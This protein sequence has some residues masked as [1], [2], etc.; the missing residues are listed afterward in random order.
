MSSANY[1]AIDDDV[2]AAEPR[3]QQPQHD[4][5]PAAPAAAVAAASGTPYLAKLVIAYTSSNLLALS[6][7][8][9]SIMS[10]LLFLLY[11]KSNLLVGIIACVYGLSS[12]GAAMGSA[13]ISD[14]AG[15]VYRPTVLY[16][17]AGLG[18]VGVAAMSAAVA[19]DYSS[20]GGLNRTADE[21][22]SLPLYVVGNFLCG[23]Y[24][25]ASSANV[26]T[27]I[28]SA[29]STGQRDR[30]YA[31]KFVFETLAGVGGI[32]SS[33]VLFLVVGND[34][35]LEALSYGMFLGLFV[36]ALT[37]ILLCMVARADR[38]HMMIEAAA[39]AAAPSRS[40]SVISS[41]IATAAAAPAPAAVATTTPKNERGETA[42]DDRDAND[43]DDDRAAA[44]CACW[45]RAPF[46]LRR[47]AIPYVV[48][49]QAVIVALGS[50]MTMRFLVLF[51]L[52]DYGASPIAVV[53]CLFSAIVLQAI[54]AKLNQLLSTPREA[55]DGSG[56]RRPLTRI[57]TTWISRV[58]GPLGLVWIGVVTTGA[59]A[60]MVPTMVV[61]AL[62]LAIMNSTV[63]LTR[64][65]TIDCVPVDSRA[66]WN[67]VESVLGASWAGSALL[68]GY[69][70]DLYGYRST[71]L[72]T[73]SVHGVAAVL[74]T[75]G[76]CT[77]EIEVF[78]AE[79]R[80][81][82]EAA[83]QRRRDRRRGRRD[84]AAASDTGDTSRYFSRALADGSINADEEDGRETAK[85][86]PDG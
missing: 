19:S 58:V 33:V 56:P 45:W 72:I 67:A 2:R 46:S 34:W 47:E 8:Y 66:R 36:Q 16:A 62:R 25:G 18:A 38:A 3:E 11:N 44:C 5:A 68:G 1:G 69:L 83:R 35:S 65:L 77:P 70:S 6:I 61:I 54:F 15:G 71:F 43:A 81:R 10:P 22:T 37:L 84:A 57:Q 39:A 12:F 78:E 73:A 52:E 40:S 85:L 75:M 53:V 86:L 14:R 7:W 60:A 64:A 80:A 30:I 21:R 51:L 13:S 74:I 32:V 28:A 24:A 20:A 26:E 48:A 9:N 27:S 76:L 4:V 29:V 82:A 23:V 42:A 63:G 55:S 50:G 79:D 49:A 59:L 31:N 41:T 17:S